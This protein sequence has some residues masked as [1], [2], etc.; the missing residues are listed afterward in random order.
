[1]PY[2]AFVAQVLADVREG[3]C[4]A[5]EHRY[6]TH[7]ERAH[8]LPTPVRQAPTESGRPGFRDIAYPEYRLVIELDGR[9]FHSE[10]VSRDRDLERDLDAAVGELLQS[11]RLG[12]GQGAVRV[13]QAARKVAELLRRRGRSG[14][15]HPCA[16]PGCPVR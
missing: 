9:L 8:G 7:V 15:P 5:L 1:M 16:T 12:W 14:T 4:S 2:R 6:L 13:C 11:V 3:T 10:S